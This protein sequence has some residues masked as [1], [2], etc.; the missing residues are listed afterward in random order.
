MGSRVPLTGLRAP[1]T[2]IDI[3]VWHIGN[4]LKPTSRRA[5]FVTK[6]DDTYL[7][8]LSRAT[9]IHVPQQN[10]D[11]VRA[12]LQRLAQMADLVM[13]F[14]LPETEEPITKLRHE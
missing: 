13:E 11:G 14:P 10:R 1:H 3:N 9:D 2:V 8:S 12:Q 4:C 7:V 6:I 5:A